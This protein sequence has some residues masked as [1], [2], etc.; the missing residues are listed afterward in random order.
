MNVESE[1]EEKILD[2]AR[3]IFQKRGF[4]GARMQEIADEA[5][6][7]KSML[8]YYYRNKDNLFMEVFQ[9]GIKKIFPQL[10]AIMNK[11]IPLKDKVWEIVEFY[12]T[13]FKENSHLPMFVIHEM[14]QHP[15]RFRDFI[16][17]VGITF[18][19]KF[20]L[21][22]KKEVQDGNIIPISPQQFLI[23]I[24]SMCM[25]PMIAR[26]M[27]MTVF[28]FNEDQYEQ[29]MDEREELIPDMIFKG[30]SFFKGV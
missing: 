9:S 30:V 11:D 19:E 24:V 18:P 22:I 5:G 20:A 12:H 13:M 1:T 23:N 4:E 27:V 26:T 10:F 25:M 21:Q 15:E 29:F 3:T 8:H 2:A 28:Q 6:I 17:K 16:Q 7:N 14:N